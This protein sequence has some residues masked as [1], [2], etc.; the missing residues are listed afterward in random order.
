MANVLIIKNGKEALNQ[1]VISFQ[2]LYSKEED[3]AVKKVL[4][5][6]LSPEGAVAEDLIPFLDDASIDEVVLK[7]SQ[8]TEL[9][10]TNKYTAIDTMSRTLS[11]RG[12]EGEEESFYLTVSFK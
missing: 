8:G 6:Q 2:E 1:E 5:V 11:P 4:S 12:P 9:F 3:G 7:G 10:R